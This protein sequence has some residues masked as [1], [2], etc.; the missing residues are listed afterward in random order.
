MCALYLLGVWAVFDGVGLV[1]AG[2][3]NR[4][5]IQAQDGT[6]DHVGRVLE[7]VTG[8]D[9]LLL[10]IVAAEHADLLLAALLATHATLLDDVVDHALR[11][12]LG[13]ERFAR[14][15]D[16]GDECGGGG[17]RVQRMVVMA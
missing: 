12:S 7:R 1:A 9:L 8:E 5:L 3:A 2:V 4:T 6:G 17:R 11:E 15:I 16:G 10:A 13:A 14:R